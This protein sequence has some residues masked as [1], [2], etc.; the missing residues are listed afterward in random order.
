VANPLFAPVTGLPGSVN[1][2]GWGEVCSYLEYQ[3][4]KPSLANQQNNFPSSRAGGVSTWRTTYS[5]AYNTDINTGANYRVWGLRGDGG[6]LNLPQCAAADAQGFPAGFEVMV[7]G[8]SS[9]RE[10]CGRLTLMAASA[11]V[12]AGPGGQ[13]AFL[14]SQTLIFGSF[15]EAF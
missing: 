4:Y 8:P 7:T 10:L 5:V 9:G 6:L 13:R 12:K 14:A 3:R 15:R 11:A 2:S 1:T